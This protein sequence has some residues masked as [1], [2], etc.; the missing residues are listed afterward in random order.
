[1]AYITVMYQDDSDIYPCEETFRGVGVE[2]EPETKNTADYFRYV[3]TSYS[4]SVAYTWC[5]M[6]E[7]VM[8]EHFCCRNLKY[9]VGAIDW[10]SF[11]QLVLRPYCKFWM[12]N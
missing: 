6:T 5:F 3:L 2:S 10:H 9:V 8:R 7:Y 11:S 1:M 12:C 4:Y